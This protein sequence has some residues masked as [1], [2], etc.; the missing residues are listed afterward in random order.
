M[1]LHNAH[2]RVWKKCCVNI[3]KFHGR[4]NECFLHSK[5]RAKSRYNYDLT[6]EDYDNILHIIFGRKGP[7]WEKEVQYIEQL[8]RR[9]L[10]LGVLYNNIWFVVVYRNAGKKSRYI[11]TFLPYDGWNP[12]RIIK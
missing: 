10:K 1:M 2:V 4:K 3:H 9:T 8:D 11:K 7:R 5:R 12:P 6:E